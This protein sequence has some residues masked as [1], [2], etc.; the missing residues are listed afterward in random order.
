MS[1][2]VQFSLPADQFVLGEILEV[3]DG[4]AVRL[5]SMVPTGDAMVPYFWVDSAH[6]DAVEAALAGS[7]MVDDV[8]RV[9]ETASEA[10]FRVTWS[11]GVN[12]FLELVRGTGAALLE[13]RG[14]GDD[15]LFRMRFPERTA[16][17]AFYQTCVDAGLRPDLEGVNYPQ[18][19]DGGLEYNISDAQRETL[20]TALERGYFDVPRGINLTELA[21]ELGISDTAVSQRL[22]RGMASLLSGTLDRQ[23]SADETA[24]RE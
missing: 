15:W 11:D 20:L 23:P 8:A 3:G 24:D 6:A 10:L 18:Q 4:P 7:E 19:S 5:E 16:V 17:S 9:E 1:V 22:R 12:G 21:E 13:A 14:R 2:V